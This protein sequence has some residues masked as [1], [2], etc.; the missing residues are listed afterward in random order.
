M[1][2]LGDSGRVISTLPRSIQVFDWVRA[3]NSKCSFYFPKPL[4][5]AV[6]SP[7]ASCTT[8]TT[9]GFRCFSEGCRSIMTWTA[10]TSGTRAISAFDAGVEPAGLRDLYVSME[11][12]DI[13]ICFA[14]AFSLRRTAPVTRRDE[15]EIT[16]GQVRASESPLRRKSLRCATRPARPTAATAGLRTPRSLAVASRPP[17]GCLLPIS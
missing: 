16:V 14:I 9:S 3:G 10:S 12:S 17:P 8:A 2:H 6:I 13:P 15:R 11:G 5:T 7:A 1:D 4:R